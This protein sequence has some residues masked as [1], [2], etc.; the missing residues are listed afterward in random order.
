MS[1]KD[2]EVSHITQC[3]FTLLRFLFDRISI[4][5]CGSVRSHGSEARRAARVRALPQRKI[6]FESESVGLHSAFKLFTVPCHVTLIVAYLL[7][8]GWPVTNQW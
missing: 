8:L 6:V 2:C 3:L 5:A 7:H 1:I 4:K